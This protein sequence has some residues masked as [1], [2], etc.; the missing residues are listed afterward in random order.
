MADKKKDNKKSENPLDISIRI[1]E[2]GE[3]EHSFDIDKVNEFLNE[4][5]KDWRIQEDQKTN[6][7]NKEEEE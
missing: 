4:N 3:I 6:A 1:N 7:S 2:F 5:I